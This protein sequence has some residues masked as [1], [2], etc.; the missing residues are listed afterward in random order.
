MKWCLISLSNN[1]QITDVKPTGLYCS[2]LFLE[3]FFK[4][5]VLYLLLSILTELFLPLMIN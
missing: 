1:L 2:D 5:K 3:P 4:I